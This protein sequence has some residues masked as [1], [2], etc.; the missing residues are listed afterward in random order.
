MVNFL[1]KNNANPNISTEDSETPLHHA[2]V[3]EF[4]NIM[5]ML[6][7][8][9]ANVNTQDEDKNTPLHC[10]V[11]RKKEKAVDLLIAHNADANIRN[12]K[13]LT[14]L[15]KFLAIEGLQYTPEEIGMTYIFDKKQLKC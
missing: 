15:H 9:G 7:N 4:L 8:K 3:N 1:L 5:T 13:G 12:S 11:E 10:A 14:P 6:L 2:S